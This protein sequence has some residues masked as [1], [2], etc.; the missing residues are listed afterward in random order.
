MEKEK[1]KLI[2]RL[3]FKYRLVLIND[4]TFEEKFSFKLTPI[5]V[6]GVTSSFIVM[7]SILIILMIFYTPLK[8]YV[9]GYTDSQTKRNIQLLLYKTDSLQ[10]ALS[11]KEAY[12]KN[13]IDILNGGEGIKKEE[14]IPPNSGTQQPGKIENK[15][16]RS[17]RK[18]FEESLIR[19]DYNVKQTADHLVT[20]PNYYLINPAEGIV[21]RKFN[22][23]D[24]HYAVDIV[25]KANAAVKAIQEG[26]IILSSWT[27]ESGNTL[28]IQHK[29]NLVSIYKHNSA[30]L[31]KVGTFV[32]TGEVV[33]IVG[34]SGEITTGPHLHFELWDEGNPRN[35]EDVLNLF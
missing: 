23:L 2:H 33:A 26:V 27:P 31:K 9:P 18:T 8:E 3:R 12:Y 32:N 34:N 5:N 19:D 14:E 35:P 24:E 4:E 20:N 6:L 1:K 13:L 10:N 28:A 30:L 11:A 22:V 7:F 25:C 17:F 29:N 15:K 21:S 16:E